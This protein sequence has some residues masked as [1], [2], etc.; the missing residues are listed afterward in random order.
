MVHG[1]TFQM[2]ANLCFRYQN[3]DGAAAGGRIRGEGQA[4]QS[5]EDRGVCIPHLEL[6][7]TDQ[8][9]M[10]DAAIE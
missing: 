9:K 7:L 10:D 1:P 6:A 3:Q 2:L 4:I 8:K 5:G